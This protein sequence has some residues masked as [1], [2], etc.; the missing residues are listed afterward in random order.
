MLSCYENAANWDQNMGNGS[1][2]QLQAAKRFSFEEPKKYTN[3]FSKTNSIGSG[4]FG[5]VDFDSLLSLLF[6]ILH[7]S[8]DACITYRYKKKNDY[9]KVKTNLNF[10]SL[11]KILLKAN[12]SAFS[13]YSWI[14]SSDNQMSICDHL[15]RFIRELFPLG[16]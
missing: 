16:N 15:Y 10:Y 3:N 2:P 9:S 4:G 14:I 1:V 12:F 8:L 11:K 7:D 6:I 13:E 5:K